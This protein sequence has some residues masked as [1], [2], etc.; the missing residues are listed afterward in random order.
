[1]GEGLAAELPDGVDALVGIQVVRGYLR[2]A[3][4]VPFEP[5]KGLT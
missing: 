3:R 4:V 5:V 1:M 2:P